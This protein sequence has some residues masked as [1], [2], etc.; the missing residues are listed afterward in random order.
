M[1]NRTVRQELQR[2]G[3]HLAGV[4]AAVGQ[5]MIKDIPFAADLLYAAVGRAGGVA[6]FPLSPPVIAHIAIAHQRPSDVEHTKRNK[7]RPIIRQIMQ[8]K[9]TLP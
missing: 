1:C 6:A 9:E 2:F 5:P 3:A 8:I 4:V 7:G